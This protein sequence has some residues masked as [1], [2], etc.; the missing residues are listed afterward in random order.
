MRI[1]DVDK[2]KRI[3]MR[4]VTLLFPRRRR[5]RPIRYGAWEFSVPQLM[6]EAML[7]REPGLYAIQVRHWWSGIKPIEFGASRNLHEEVMVEGHAGFVQWLMD[8]G[9][10]RGVYVSFQTLPDI[11]HDARH[12]EGMR[13]NRHYFPHRTHSVDEH[14][15]GH[16]IHRLPRP[17]GSNPSKEH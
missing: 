11:D 10:K 14:L 16:R 13:L 15:A 9:S 12:R 5:H 3:V 8:R 2:L 7:P 4:A 1:F 17:G 6:T